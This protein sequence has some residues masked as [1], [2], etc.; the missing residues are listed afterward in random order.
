LGRITNLPSQDSWD[1]NYNAKF[2]PNLQPDHGRGLDVVHGNFTNEKLTIDTRGHHGLMGNQSL[3]FDQSIID[4]WSPTGAMIQSEFETYDTVIVPTTTPEPPQSPLPIFNHQ[5]VSNVAQIPYHP[6]PKRQQTF[7]YP[8]FD[9]QKALQLS[10]GLQPA[11]PHLVAV[12]NLRES[13][14]VNY[15]FPSPPIS[16]TR[17]RAVQP[18][19]SSSPP[20]SPLRQNVVNPEIQT[21][22][23]PPLPTQAPP[24]TKIPQPVRGHRNSKPSLGYDGILDAMVNNTAGELPPHEGLKEFPDSVRGSNDTT[25]F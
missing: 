14:Q 20:R 12:S 24:Q 3:G 23:T 18:E 25:R 2:D 19:L 6:E 21:S 8:H 5:N 15:S 16:P 1:N 22:P 7:S 10:Q 17:P 9:Q 13:I 11:K 4:Q